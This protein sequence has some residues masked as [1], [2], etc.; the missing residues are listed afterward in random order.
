MLRTVDEFEII[1]SLRGRFVGMADPSVLVGVGDDAAVIRA[2]EG[3]SLIVTT[4]TVVEGVHLDL[5]LSSPGDA[6][7]KA[8]TSAVSDLAAM[9]A[10]AR[11]VLVAAVLPRR[12]VPQ[13]SA[14]AEG[15]D[16]AARACGVAIVG[17]DTARGERLSLTVTAIG[18]AV[19]PVLRT[20]ARP[21]DV[22][23]VTGALGAAASGLALLSAE[24]ARMVGA[25]DLLQA[26]P[27]LARAHRRPSARLTEGIALAASGARAMIDLSDG[28]G[29]DAGHLLTADVPGVVIDPDALPCAP[30]VIE[31]AALLRTDARETAVAGGEDYELAVA[32]EEAAVEAARAAIAPTP[33][34]TVGRFDVG[35]G[36]R[37][38]S[39]ERVPRGW[40]HFA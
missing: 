28:L 14:I 39:G 27:G 18:T 3:A 6:G 37:W 19:T 32:L 30:G 34:T 22:L 17:G 36:V 9:G 21:G 11:W 10:R 29:S 26:H 24:A 25:S 38:T 4:D 31:V 2:P 16:E 8:V 1:T 15:L 7:Y 23:C 33:L 40:D 35:D 20:G 12:L 5:A 13:A